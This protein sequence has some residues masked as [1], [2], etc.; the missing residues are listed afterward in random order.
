MRLLSLLHVGRLI[1]KHGDGIRR[2]MNQL[3]R[4]SDIN[5]HKEKNKKKIY[6]LES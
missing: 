1:W 3:K 6:V 4:F 5:Y 2:L